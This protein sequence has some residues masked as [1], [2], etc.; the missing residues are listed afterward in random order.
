ME[1]IPAL[2]V[3]GVHVNGGAL[4]ENRRSYRLTPS[5]VDHNGQIVEL[6]ERRLAVG[7]EETFTFILSLKPGMYLATFS[8]EGSE[9]DLE[10]AIQA[11]G[12]DTADIAVWQVSD[13]FLVPEKVQA[14]R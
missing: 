9:L 5:K 7:D 2:A 14:V 8:S 10:D 1:K 4:I 13:Y 3:S 12:I 11:K 6:N